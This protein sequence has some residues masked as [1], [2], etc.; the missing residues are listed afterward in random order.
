VR[1]W[2]F[3]TVAS[4][5]GT[6]LFSIAGLAATKTLDLQSEWLWVL[7]LA[8][9][10]ISVT[11]LVLL[12][13]SRRSD[14]DSEPFAQSSDELEVN[15]HR[16]AQDSFDYGAPQ[17]ID[18]R[19]QFSEIIARYERNLSDGSYDIR[20]R[21]T[22]YGRR[23]SRSLIRMVAG[24]SAIDASRLNL[25][26]SL[27]NGQPLDWE[28]LEDGATPFRKPFR[29]FFPQPLERG[30]SFEFRVSCSWPGTFGRKEDYDFFP[31]H[32]FRRGVDRFR[33]ESVFTAPPSR[34][35]AVF[36][37]GSGYKLAPIQP[38]LSQENELW[39]VTSELVR[40]RQLY[41]VWYRRTDI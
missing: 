16:I 12:R 1:K 31:L 17:L 9:L 19:H 5:L 4:F 33:M 20:Y 21:G 6:V 35:Q 39:V 37:K 7:P 2:V 40:P 14:R 8:G 32:T 28:F 25:Q 29:V 18:R 23:P 13:R 3:A 15:L 11:I 30:R 36:F 41:A 26:V 22:N 34:F 10:G 38:R 24:D 27:P